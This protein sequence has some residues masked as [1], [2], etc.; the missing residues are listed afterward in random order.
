MSFVSLS[1]FVFLAVS[2]VA[3]YICPVRY[4]WVVLLAASVAFYSMSGLEYLPFFFLTSLTI[5]LGSRFIA[6]NWDKQ[7]GELSAE[8]LAREDKKAIKEKFKK[9]NKKILILTLVIN[10]GILCAVKFGKFFISPLN[11]LISFLGGEGSLSAKSIIVPLGIS[12]YTFSAVSYLLDVYWKRYEDEK[13]FFR[14]FL[15]VSFFPHI[16]QGPIENYS[17]LGQELKKEL[18]FDLQNVVYGVELLLWGYFKKLVVADRLGIL[19]DEAFSNSTRDFGVLYLVALVFDVFS[20]YADFSGCMDIA[21]GIS[22]VFGVKLDLNFEQPFLSTSVAEFWRRWHI[23]LGAWFR[24]YVYYPVSTSSLVKNLNKKLKKANAP[25]LLIKAVCTCI[26]VFVTWILTG[27]WH[28]TG[29][30]YV[31]WGLYYAALIGLSTVFSEPFQNLLKKLGFKTD[32]FSWKVLRTLKVFVIFMFGRLL[33]TTGT[34]QNTL[35]VIKSLLVTHNFWIF[36]NGTFWKICGMEPSQFLLSVLGIIILIAVDIL[37][38]KDERSLR[39]RISQENL[40]TRWILVIGLVLAIAMFGIY[41]PE[42]DASSF[43]YMAY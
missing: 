17:R 25:K 38:A 18:R 23:S 22:Q 20:L 36:T 24:D 34:L 29:A 43:V 31:V 8:G 33:T 32:T 5:F 12:Y 6:K 21:R 27:V 26:P 15:Y 3:F 16:L 2:V 30:N 11:E 41:G 4:R 19:V 1:F 42:Y 13:N 14:F 39:E 7:K 10:I 40:F 35:A 37:Q 9:K 28:G